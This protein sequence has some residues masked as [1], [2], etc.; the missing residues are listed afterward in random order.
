MDFLHRTWAEIDTK[1]LIHNLNI[2]KAK[3]GDKKFMA[4]VKADDLLSRAV[5]SQ[6]PS[7]C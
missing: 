5:A 6:V 3:L 7:A 2:F 1:A 4:V